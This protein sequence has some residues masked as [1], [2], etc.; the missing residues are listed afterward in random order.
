MTISEGE[1]KGAPELA[2]RR[3]KSGGARSVA[4]L[5]AVQALYQ[6]EM[7]QGTAQEVIQE[8]LDHRLGY[9]TD[10]DV[11]AEPDIDFFTDIVKGVVRNQAEIDAS[12]AENLAEDWSFERI[13]NIL[14]CIVRAGLYELRF[15]LDVPTKVIINEYVDVAHA[16]YAQ[17]EPAFVN[18]ILDR[19]AKKTRS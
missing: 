14:K 17:S 8:F 15:R 1:N 16:F 5:E 3:K 11:Y 2:A 9:D 13:D 7:A 10:D 19:L 4:R 12:I 18:G 6:R